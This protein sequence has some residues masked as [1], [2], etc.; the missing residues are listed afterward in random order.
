MPQ[1]MSTIKS[2]GFDSPER[3]HPMPQR[4]GLSP[5]R[6]TSTSS[7]S[8]GEPSDR[9]MLPMPQR[10]VQ[11]NVYETDLY[12][13]KYIQN[14]KSDC[15]LLYGDLHVFT[16]SCIWL[17]LTLKDAGGGGGGKGGYGGL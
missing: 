12:S 8:S 10:Y 7:D 4:L 9:H 14:M 16:S 15:L 17:L 2:H 6:T 13:L 11:L 5:P 1:R 3:S